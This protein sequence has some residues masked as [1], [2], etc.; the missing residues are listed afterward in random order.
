MSRLCRLS[1]RIFP[2]GTGKDSALRAFP[3]CHAQNKF[4]CVTSLHRT[5][6]AAQKIGFSSSSIQKENASTR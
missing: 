5:P 4:L 3:L 1:V 6:F 2:L